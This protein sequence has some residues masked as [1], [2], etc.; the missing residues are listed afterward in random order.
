MFNNSEKDVYG[1][2]VTVQLPSSLTY[3]YPIINSGSIESLTTYIYNNDIFNNFYEGSPRNS[4]SWIIDVIPY[5]TIFTVNV[6]CQ[7]NTSDTPSL[8][9]S[10]SAYSIISKLMDKHSYPNVPATNDIN[11]T[12]NINENWLGIL[13]S[14]LSILSYCLPFGSP[15]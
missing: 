4:F 5:N 10:S 1:L 12:V 2:K 8:P 13:D 14:H 11:A 3:L 7:I 6:I 9:T 15:I